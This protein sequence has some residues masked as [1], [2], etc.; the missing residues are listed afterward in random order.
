[1]K[2]L[3]HLWKQAARAAAD[4]SSDSDLLNRFI[5]QRD[6]AA[7]AQLVDRHGPLV[8]GTCRRL[9]PNSVDAEDAFQATFLVLVRRA[10]QLRGRA[11]GPWLHQVAVWSARNLQRR[12]RSRV[13]LMRPLE[14]SAPASVPSGVAAVDS[15]L[16]VDD[17]LSGL[18]KK[19]RVPLIL[20]HLQGWTHQ[21]AAVYLGCPESTLASLLRRGLA[22]LRQRH[23]RDP[24][25]VLAIAGSSVVSSA[26]SGAAVRAAVLYRTSSLSIAASPVV[27]ELT[28]GVLRMFWIKKLAFVS[29]LV[30]AVGVI[31]TQVWV[32]SASGPTLQASALV[33]EESQPPAAPKKPVQIVPPNAASTLPDAFPDLVPPKQLE[34]F[35]KQLIKDFTRPI[36]EATPM[37]KKVRIA[38]MNNGIIY[39]SKM[40]EMIRVGNWSQSDYPSLINMVK[41]VFQVAAELETTGAGKISAYEMRVKAFKWFEQFVEARVNAGTDKP[42]NLNYARFYL[43]QSE[44]ELLQLKES[45]R[46]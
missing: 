34:E 27:A 36:P 24:A 20:C 1:M 33:P 43:L 4:L 23:G 18:P 42:H 38:Q 10:N 25:I 46:K 44:A 37:L 19:Y 30:V 28:Q 41:E 5:Q 35:N 11:L 31:G 2:R 8:Y 40:M 7:F 22:K 17:L 16:D 32:G 29:L 21:Q 13:A 12:N 9:L 26:L 45:L 6:E 39:M 15:R 3:F 14:E